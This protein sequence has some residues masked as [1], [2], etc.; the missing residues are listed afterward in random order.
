MTSTYYYMSFWLLPSSWYKLLSYVVWICISLIANCSEHIF[1]FLSVIWI[2]SMV[3]CRFKSFAHTK[4]WVI[5]LLIELKD[6][7]MYYGFY[8]CCCCLLLY[9]LRK[10]CSLYS[11][12]ISIYWCGRCFLPEKSRFILT[13]C[14]LDWGL[15]GEGRNPDNQ[16]SGTFLSAHFLIF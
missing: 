4:N 5:C 2:P 9:Q 10:G 1:T 7:F 16:I 11:L 6:L 8:M 13:L 15:Q 14:H 12:S 3:Q